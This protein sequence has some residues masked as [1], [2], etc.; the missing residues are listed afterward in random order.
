MRLIHCL[1]VL[2]V[3]Y[4][5][6]VQ[7]VLQIGKIPSL[8]RYSDILNIPVMRFESRIEHRKER[9]CLQA[10]ACRFRSQQS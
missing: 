3:I 6:V 7:R 8:N 4:R 2:R 5:F 10:G 1:E 9:G